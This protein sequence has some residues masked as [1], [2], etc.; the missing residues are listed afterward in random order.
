MVYSVADDLVF[1]VQVPSHHGLH[2]GP[3][4]DGHEKLRASDIDALV[5]RARRERWVMG[6]DENR[7]VAVQLVCQGGEC[8]I[9]ERATV[10]AR[11]E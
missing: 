3:L 1:Q 8:R 11:I 9:G 10:F 6:P 4:V 7:A 5:V 2:V